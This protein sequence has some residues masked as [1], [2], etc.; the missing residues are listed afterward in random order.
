M[1]IILSRK[2]FDSSAGGHASPILPTGQMLS[3]PVPSS[4]DSIEY[5]S[6]AAPGNRTVGG[7]IRELDAN[8]KI[9]D[10]GAH[11]DPDLIFGARKRGEGWTPSL[12]QIGAASGHLRNQG[13]QVDD[14]F[15][16][17]GWFRHTEEVDSRL[18]FQRDGFGCHAIYGYLKVGE[19]I[20]ASDVT[21]L[22]TWLHDH[23][24]ANK[25]RLAKSTNAIYLARKLLK[26]GSDLPGAGVFEYQDRLVLT[27]SGQSRSRWSLDPAVFKSLQISY[28]TQGAWKDGYFQ[29]YLRAQEYV[30]HAD[31]RAER[32]ANDLI[33][34]AKRWIL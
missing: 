10:K 32:W 24:H 34:G 1:R 15:V 4:L 18:T 5:D 12:G 20:H 22:P 13:V 21:A 23:P 30:I 14:L 7:I 33:E 16:F 9:G 27:K 8:A 3:L 11:A 29:S 26:S 17:Y 25:E 28:H 31:K 6:L 19:I 2:G